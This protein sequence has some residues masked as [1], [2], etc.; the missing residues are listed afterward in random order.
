MFSKAAWLSVAVI[1]FS[2]FTLN[3]QTPPNP[4]PPPGE[5]KPAP[6]DYSDF[7]RLLHK[8]VIAN[9]PK[10]MENRSQWGP[11]IPLPNK[12][13]LK[14]AKRTFVK[15]G[16]R[17]EVPHGLW[18]RSRAW[19]DDPAKDVQIQVRDFKKSDG[20]TLRLSLDA[21]ASIHG[22]AER[23][24]WNKG[25]S[26]FH[27]QVQADATFTMAMECDIVVSFKTDKFPPQLIVEPKI[28][29][30]KLTLKEFLPR[31]LNNLKLEDDQAREVGNELK[32]YLQQLLT[33]SEPTLKQRIQE[34]IIQGLKD[35]KG[36]SV[37]DLLKSLGS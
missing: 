8:L 29:E 2:N 5:P 7:S 20:K 11:S 19:I 21:Q 26:L 24:R 25:L 6:R 10:E 14:N 27:V 15:V 34:A 17:L 30:C 12:L 37:L 33:L 3:A 4:V 22:E 1:G 28:V 18:Q 23:Q 35:N 36:P 9:A 16:D 31:Q 13:L 32:A